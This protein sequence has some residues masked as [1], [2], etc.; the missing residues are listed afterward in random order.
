MTN[1]DR[2]KFNTRERLISSDLNLDTQLVH[3]AIQEAV[4]Y[5]LS[6]TTRESGVFGDSYL[7][8][9]MVGTM[10]CAIGPGL[11]VM[12][13]TTQAYPESQSV[14]M[15][16]RAVREVTHDPGGA[17]SRYDVIEVRP[18][19]QVSINVPRDQFDPLTGTFSAVSVDKQVESYPEFR[20]VKGAEALTP[21]L[22]AGS[23]GWMPLAYIF[24]PVGA[25]A[26]DPQDVIYCRPLLAPKQVQESG[27]SSPS[28]DVY[29]TDV[30]GGGLTA[31][32]A[33]VVATLNTSVSGRFRNHNFK[34]NVAA[35]SSFTLS[36]L[37]HDGGVLPAAGTNLYFYAVPAPYPAG[38]DA[39]VAP[40]EFWS[41]K[42]VYA[43]QGGFE[44]PTRQNGCIVVTSA[45][46]VPSSTH[47]S[48][49]PSGAAMSIS[50]PF[51]SAGAS[52]IDMSNVV[53]LGSV[54]Y[55][56]PTAQFVA[57]RASGANIGANRKTGA[58]IEPSFPIA[59]PTLFTLNANIA[60]DPAMRLPGHVRRV[61]IV[62]SAN[63]GLNSWIYAQFSDQFETVG[64]AKPVFICDK[65]LDANAL[66]S[67]TAWDFW[68]TLDS[69]QRMTCVRADASLA[70]VCGL[71]V[72]E[73]EDP[74][75]ALR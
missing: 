3:R 69:S 46:K 68:A 51:F 70:S 17:G 32:G 43:N 5:M 38:Y 29:P 73:W 28:Q 13:D 12:V 72:Y 26:L 18:A 60:A 49:A 30:K 33:G 6:G 44:N 41:P 63:I 10:K 15:E 31:P 22:P 66:Q 21:N 50:H 65:L 52:S 36:P 64:G 25:V 9:P 24:V 39:S 61:R 35:L 27:W 59:A 2:L 47:P 55:D 34:F 58:D 14:W 62:F 20:I 57:Q 8:T 71:Y 54:Y 37:T 4:A 40:R 67:F 19:T 48:G 75:I 16:S 42:Q 45:T 56:Q 53:Y 7:V 23:A 1:I 74:T 11:G